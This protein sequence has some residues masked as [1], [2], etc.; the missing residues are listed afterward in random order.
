MTARR[1][2]EVFTK[3]FARESWRSFVRVCARN[4][5]IFAFFFF[6]KEDSVVRIFNISILF[7]YRFYERFS[8]ET[9]TF[10][11]FWRMFLRN[12]F[13]NEK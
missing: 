10:V 9:K 2:I 11:E 7:I 13:M 4:L 3:K 6:C 8:F 5:N 12:I 1:E